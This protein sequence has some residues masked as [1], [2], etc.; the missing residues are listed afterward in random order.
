MIILPPKERYSRD[1]LWLLILCQAKMQRVL[2][3][4]FA[5]PPPGDG[6]YAKDAK[7]KAPSSLAV[8]PDGTLYIADLGNIRIRVVSRNKAH[9]NDMNIYEIASP[10]D[11][12]LYQF[13]S[14]GTHLHT[15]NLITRDYMY[16]FTYNGEGELSTVTNSNGNSVHIRRD[17][18]GLPLWLVM[19]GSQVYWLTISSNGVL[20][21]VYAQGYNLALMTYPGNTGL[22]ATKSNEYGWTTVYE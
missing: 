22:L 10:A 3:K 14:N 1:R 9:L 16:N 12:E 4:P 5:F 19:P 17:A 13:T 15:L 21:R 20:K 6:G 18:S 11:Q 7:L 8:S 2:I